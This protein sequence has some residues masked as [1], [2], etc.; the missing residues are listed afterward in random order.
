M[1]ILKDCAADAIGLHMGL[2]S[3]IIVA[4]LILT[5][6]IAGSILWAQRDRSLDCGGPLYLGRREERLEKKI[7][8]FGEKLDQLDKLVVQLKEKSGRAR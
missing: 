8:S 1:P 4:S 2:D 7:D 3:P 5:S 6:G